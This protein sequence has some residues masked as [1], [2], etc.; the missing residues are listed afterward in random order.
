M[1]ISE[2]VTQIEARTDYVSASLIN[3]GFDDTGTTYKWLER[4]TLPNGRQ[5]AFRKEYFVSTSGTGSL[6]SRTVLEYIEVVE[7]Q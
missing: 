4:Q 6:E 7:A 2:L 5:R 3:K 1:I